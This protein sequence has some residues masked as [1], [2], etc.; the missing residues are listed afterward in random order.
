MFATLQLAPVLQHGVNHVPGPSGL[1]VDV[2]DDL[3]TQ[4]EVHPIG[5]HS[6]L[7]A[8]CLVVR[9]EL[10]SPVLSPIPSLPLPSFP[11]TPLWL[12]L[13]RDML[14]V[15]R[16]RHSRAHLGGLEVSASRCDDVTHSNAASA[17][18]VSTG[19]TAMRRRRH[20]ND[21]VPNVQRY[22]QIQIHRC[23]SVVLETRHQDL[24]TYN[25][26]LSCKCHFLSLVYL[27]RI[28]PILT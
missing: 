5:P 23:H 3:L 26:P 15:T 17:L 8:H 27:K 4:F 22:R 14:H 21:S 20:P 18:R 6:E 10:S 7:E 16:H 24:L 25:C 2:L 1:S 28:K 11:D 19:P 12:V 13:P 9:S